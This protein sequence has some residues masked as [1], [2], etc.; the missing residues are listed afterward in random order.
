MQQP[1]SQLCLFTSIVLIYEDVTLLYQMC[2]SKVLI[3]NF[4]I[5]NNLCLFGFGMHAMIQHR[6]C[7]FVEF[8]SI[9]LVLYAS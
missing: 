2:D 6:I 3:Y 7:N 4:F 8:L 1:Y 5:S 9:Q